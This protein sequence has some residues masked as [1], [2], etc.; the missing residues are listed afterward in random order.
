VCI[1][2]V[3]KEEDEKGVMEDV[4]ENHYIKQDEYLLAV[5]SFSLTVDRDRKKRE[6]SS[7]D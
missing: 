6:E 1:V 5:E 7:S 3:C 4:L 2:A